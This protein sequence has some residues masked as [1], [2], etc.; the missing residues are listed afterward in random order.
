MRPRFPI[1]AVLVVPTLL[2]PSLACKPAADPSLAKIDQCKAIL[3]AGIEAKYALIEASHK[4]L[5]DELGGVAQI[6]PLE[7]LDPL[8][9]SPAKV[10][11]E[12]AE[13][14]R[15]LGKMIEGVIAVRAAR[16]SMLERATPKERARQAMAVAKSECLMHTKFRVL[17][18]LGTKAK[19]IEWIAKRVAPLQARPQQLEIE[20]RYVKALLAAGEYW[21]AEQK[22]G[23]ESY[24]KVEAI[25]GPK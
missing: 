5:V 11:Q 24:A 22:I 6:L 25:F 10:A 18:P 13:E 3:L 23:Q 12:K 9:W 14:I 8:N 15:S 19:R 20:G 7:G 2:A 17:D 1:A 21:Q 4:K 16:L